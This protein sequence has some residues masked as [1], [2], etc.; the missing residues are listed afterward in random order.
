MQ[1]TSLVVTYIMQKL[2][3]LH[4]R[5][6]PD[7]AVLYISLRAPGY[8]IRYGDQATAWACGELYFD[9]QRGQGL[10]LF[11]KA[12]RLTLGLTQLST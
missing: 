4:P 3:A 10:L 11:Y 5:H 7:S 12:S 6:Y 9:S 2:L 8:L 1:K